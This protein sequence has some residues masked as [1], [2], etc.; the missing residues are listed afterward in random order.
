MHP[1]QEILKVLVEILTTG[2]LRIRTLGW[3]S[4]PQRCALEADHLHNLPDLIRDFSPTRLE[5]Y[6][7]A[8]RET[9]MERSTPDDIRAFEPLWQRLSDLLAAKK[10]VPP[11]STSEHS[12]P[13][14]NVVPT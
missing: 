3:S 11:V 10:H 4:D 8:E 14:E 13:Q 1:P 2:L 6:R 12:V 7:T 5:Y 9:F